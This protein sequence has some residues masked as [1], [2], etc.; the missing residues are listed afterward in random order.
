MTAGKLPPGVAPRMPGRQKGPAR[1]QVS[2]SGPE[3]VLALRRAGGEPL[4]LAGE[5]KAPVFVEVAVADH[6]ARRLRM[7]SA[8]PN[9]AVQNCKIQQAP[10]SAQPSTLQVRQSSRRADVQAGPG[11]VLEVWAV[12]GYPA[13]AACPGCGT[14]S[15]R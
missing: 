10:A 6:C 5:V 14:V 4:V 3:G 11:G 8:P 13:A 7:A 1:P 9:P 12:T 15:G 2:G